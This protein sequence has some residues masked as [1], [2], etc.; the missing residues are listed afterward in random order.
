MIY[1]LVGNQTKKK[2]ARARSLALS[3][4]LIT[5]ADSD[6]STE[7]L[8]RHASGASLF[9]EASAIIL[10]NVLNAGTIQFTAELLSAL[11]NS[12]NICI[13][14]E[15]KLLAADE[16]KYKKYATIER[17]EEK[18]VKATPKVN[19][20]TIADLY[21]KHDKMG[22]WR[23][24]LRAI[25]S[26]V[27]PEAISGILFW[28]IKTMILGQSRAFPRESLVSHSSALVSLYHEAHLGRIDFTIGLEQFIL[29]SLSK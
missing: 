10:D 12:P 9:G 21:E 5:L 11:Q 29:T 14:T 7:S 16:K 28:K 27:E 23:E 3:H 20:F 17:Y 8:A 18:P 22:A 13:F 1:I 2:S 24:Y 26:G 4:E 15:D 6:I 19:I 25:D